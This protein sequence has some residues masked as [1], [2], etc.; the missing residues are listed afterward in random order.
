MKHTL[1]THNSLLRA[2]RGLLSSFLGFQFFYIFEPKLGF[3][4]FFDFPQ[5]SPQGEV[6]CDNRMLHFL[7]LFA[8]EIHFSI[9]LTF[10]LVYARAFGNLQ[11]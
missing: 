9:M 11:I 8:A 10:S 7:E 2:R 1:I 5:F 3:V 4:R 6:L